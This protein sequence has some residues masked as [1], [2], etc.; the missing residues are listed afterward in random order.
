ML[1]TQH[2]PQ[3]T[4][5]NRQLHQFLFW[6]VLTAVG[7]VVVYTVGWFLTAS[8]SLL[9]LTIGSIVLLIPLRE[10]AQCPSRNDSSR[11]PLLRGSSPLCHCQRVGGAGHDSHRCAAVSQP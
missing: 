5:E 2:R 11:V 7:A 10:M 6:A 4:D 9:L 1:S 8:P 3:Q